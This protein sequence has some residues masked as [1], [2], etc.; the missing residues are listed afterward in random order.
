MYEP[1]TLSARG[2][3]AGAEPTPRLAPMD[4]YAGFW[5]GVLRL[6]FR[7]M[8]GKV[9]MPLRTLFPR[10]PGYA[11]PMQLWPQVAHHKLRVTEIA[12]RLIYNDPTRHFGGMLDDASHRLRHYLDVLCAEQRR[13]DA[14]LLEQS[15]VPCPCDCV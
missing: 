13:I 12:V 3:P 14:S 8:F 4:G 10:I 9:M 7:F 1:L 6:A 11:F 5:L 2:A 15:Q